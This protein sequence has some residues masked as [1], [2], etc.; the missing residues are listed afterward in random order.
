MARYWRVEVGSVEPGHVHQVIPDGCVGLVASRRADGSAWLTLQ[1]PRLDALWVPVVAGDSYWGVRFWPDTGAGIMGRSARELFGVLER[2][3]ATLGAAA[4]GLAEML[5]TCIEE[6]DARKCWEAVLG[7]MVVSG[8][9]LD[10]AVRAAVL[11][12]VAARGSTPIGE[13]ASA[14]DLSP[15][16]LQ[17]RFS[18]AVG[19]S[20][21]Q[22]ARVR[23]L[24]EA[25]L[26]LVEGPL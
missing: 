8:R 9:A 4:A 2:A 16:Q 10:P 19:L 12:I 26:H 24:R 18:A 13:L 21:K 14:V 25:L 11:S 23:R 20:P 7:P 22:F 17:R 3:D 5:A 15:R 1:G 6:R